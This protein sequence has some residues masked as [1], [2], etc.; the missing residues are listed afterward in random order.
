MTAKP[1]PVKKNFSDKLSRVG[2][3][4]TPYHL[5]HQNSS[6]QLFVSFSMTK[7]ARYLEV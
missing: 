1:N 6:R 2:P 3:D 4:D 7:F 5:N